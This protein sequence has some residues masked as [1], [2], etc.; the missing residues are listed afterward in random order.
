[1]TDGIALSFVLLERPEY[2]DPEACVRVA[3]ELGLGLRPEPS[4]AEGP[5]AFALAGSG[6]V[7]VMLVE[8]P[9]PDAQHMPLGLASPTDED[10]ER[11]QAHYIVTAMDMPAD[12]R[13]RDPLMAALTAAIAGASPSVAA[14]LGTGVVFHRT[15]FFLDVVRS[16]EGDLPML[17]CIDVTQAAEDEE[18][19][20]ILTHGMQRY[21]R[22]EFFVTCS[23][24][25]SGALDFVLSLAGWMLD[26]PDKDLP[27]GETVGRSAEEK[28]TIQRVP[29]PLGEGPDVIRLDL[30][31]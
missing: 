5:I 16:A 21:G 20:S 15:E 9:H 26:D 7:M 17:V 12:P 24:E 28:I 13:T 30:D 25:G 22:E 14:M 4:P 3:A 18:R 31:V 23:Q 29:S 1:V 19:M 8:A 2:P 27:T 6:T 10:L 11:V